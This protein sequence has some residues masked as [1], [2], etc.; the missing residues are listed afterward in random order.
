MRDT[1]F[2]EIKPIITMET[3]KLIY[4]VHRVKPSGETEVMLSPTADSFEATVDI[5]SSKA[6]RVMYKVI[7][8][9]GKVQNKITYD[10]NK[11]AGRPIT[12]T[13]IEVE[14]KKR[15]C[16]QENYQG[17]IRQY[18]SDKIID[19]T[20]QLS[21]EGDSVFALFVLPSKAGYGFYVY[22]VKISASGTG[23]Y[24]WQEP[25]YY[26]FEDNALFNFFDGSR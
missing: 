17:S 6:S 1:E 21:N 3:P 16:D 26:S 4:S 2:S 14:I 15:T 22:C 24:R 19:I 7:A 12:S 20:P 8:S 23:N 18:I 5:T 10:F 11:T 9:N 25:T 13:E